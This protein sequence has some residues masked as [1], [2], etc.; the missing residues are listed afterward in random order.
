MLEEENLN[1]AYKYKGDGE[2]MSDISSSKPLKKTNTKKPV[3]KPVKKTVKKPV[4]NIS[5]QDIIDNVIEN[6]NFEVKIETKVI[7][8]KSILES[9]ILENRPF[10]IKMN[11]DIIFDSDN[12]SVMSLS[13]NDEYFRLN[14]IKYTYEGFNFKFKK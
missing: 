4:E 9:M 13:F 2:V 10:I 6:N 1:D 11:G 12:Q 8:Q 3:K 5:V 14:G 7:S